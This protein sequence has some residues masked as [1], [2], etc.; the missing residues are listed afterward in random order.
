MDTIRPNNL[1]QCSIRKHT[2]SGD[3]IQTSARI[4]AVQLYGC[5]P[6]AACVGLL[7]RSH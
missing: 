4:T 5:F 6:I 3:Y 7:L 2:Y 1:L